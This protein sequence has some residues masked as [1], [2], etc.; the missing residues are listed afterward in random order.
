MK[1][2]GGPG[3]LAAGTKV[4]ET[5]AHPTQQES[6]CRHTCCRRCFGDPEVGGYVVGRYAPMRKVAAVSAVELPLIMSSCWCT[7]QSA[8][9]ETCVQD[10]VAGGALA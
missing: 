9:K 10:C 5:W 7:E 2:Q 1:D 6:T 4:H 8:H 3:L